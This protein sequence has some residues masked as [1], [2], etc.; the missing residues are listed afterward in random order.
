MTETEVLREW[1]R[2]YFWHPFTQ[3]QCYGDDDP[4][5]IER[6]EGNYVYDTEGHRCLD[7]I[8]SL[9]CNIH[10]HRHPRL[11]AALVEQIGKVAHST[12]LGASHPP[13][14]HLARALVEITPA[15][16]QHCFFSEDGSE[17]VEVAIKM[18]AQYWCNLGRPE[19]HLFLTLDNA[20]HGDTVGAVS[21]GGF[22]LFHEVYGH[23]L[24]PT[25]RLPSPYVLQ[26]EDCEGDPEQATAAWLA[27]LE[28]ILQSQGHE[29]A[30]LILEGGVQGA[31]GILPFPPGIL[32]GAQRLC[33]AYEVLLI[34]DEVATGFGRSGKLFSCEWESVEPDLLALGKG[35][36]GGYLPVAATLAA[37]HVY[38][39]FLAPFGEARQFYYGHTY[40]ANP[41]A[42]AVALE[43]LALF[44]E[45]GVLA[46]LPEKIAQLRA[47]LQRFHGQSWAGEVRQFGLM[48]AIALRDP[49]TN[50][51][52]PY[53]D[54]VEY[55]V[56][57]RAREM[58]VY[59][60]PLG[61]LLTIVPPLS[62]TAAEIDTIL[63]VLYDAMAE[64]RS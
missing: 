47:G 23:L 19:K 51:P 8:A 36:S 30:A 61:D 43:N 60:R 40:T 11:D 12:A 24:F 5:I 53:G 3:M 26:W 29:I 28:S 46:A 44:A 25:L 64:G 6:A 56:C 54:R 7:A 10:G 58:G 17:A 15:S 16:L 35:L 48:A 41:L 52:Y 18:A 59:S 32:A 22:P 27:A 34:I 55:A 9:W 49:R 39:A 4:W 33:R 1:D 21:V 45:G 2:R 13:A 20:Y 38:A 63:N 37:E 57:R 42:C 31:A 50:A 14:I 62:V